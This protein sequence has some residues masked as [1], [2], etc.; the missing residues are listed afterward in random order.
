MNMQ[1]KQALEEFNV[2]NKVKMYT[3]S[4]R[5]YSYQ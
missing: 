5:K 2:L 3:K 4:Y 1:L